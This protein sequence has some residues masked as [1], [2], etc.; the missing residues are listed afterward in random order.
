MVSYSNHHYAE[1]IAALKKWLEHTPNSG[2]AWAVMGLSEFELKDYDNA[3]IHLGRGQ[4]LGLGGNFESVQLAKYRLGILLNRNGQFEAAEEILN[5]VAGKGPLAAEVRFALGMS[6]L[7]LGILPGQVENAKAPL[8]AAMGEIAEMLKDS[9]Y[10]EAFP[11]F[12]AVLKQNPSAPFVHYVYGTALATLSRY[13]E[14]GEQLQKEILLMPASELP[15]LQLASI[16]LKRHRAENALAPA[17]QAV[18]LAP[19]SAGNP[20]Y[21]LGRAY[22]ELGNK[23]AS[24]GRIETASKNH[25]KQPANSFQSGEGLRENESAGKSRARARNFC[26]PERAGR[27]ATQ[28]TRIAILWRAQCR[29]FTIF[30]SGFGQTRFAGAARESRINERIEAE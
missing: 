15:Y 11:K 5:G 6:L 26:G 20:L 28:S 12:E 24:G 17:Q 18:K 16:A 7:R 29:G 4:E 8:V 9:R 30:S 1:A 23:A 25:A 21:L 10:D 13:D 14:A 19:S 3:L 22:L 2:T 27:R